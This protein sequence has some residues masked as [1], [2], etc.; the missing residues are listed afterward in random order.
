M[1]IVQD[2][3]SPKFQHL[4]EMSDSSLDSYKRFLSRERKARKAAECLL[5]AK[6]LEL[7][8]ANQKLRKQAQELDAR[9]KERTQQFEE[10]KAKAEAGAKAKSDFLANMSHEIR[11]PLNAIIGMNNLLLEENLTTR[12][13]EFVHAIHDSS[14]VLLRIINDILDFSKVA[15]GKLDIEVVEFSLLEV[16]DSVFELLRIKALN[17]GILFHF[18]IDP[19]IPERLNGDSGRL[20]Q[21][22]LNLLDNGIKFTS[23]GQV[24]LRLKCL[25]SDLDSCMV[26]LDVVD[27]GIGMSPEQLDVVFNPFTQA[28]EA[29]SRNYG[30]TGLGLVIAQKIVE[31][32]GGNL[33]VTSKERLG[34]TFTLSLPF[35]I[36]S[37][38]NDNNSKNNLADALG[39]DSDFL[40][41]DKEGMLYESIVS[42]LSYRGVASSINSSIQQSLR[43]VVSESG[44]GKFFWIL[45]FDQLSSVE[46]EMIR[47]FIRNKPE[48]VSLLLLVK[49]QNLIREFSDDDVGVLILPL[50]AKSFF[51]AIDDQVGNKTDV[52]SR[53]IDTQKLNKEQQFHDLR[54]LLAEDNPINQTVCRELLLLLGV[55]VDIAANGLEVL[56]MIDLFEYDLILMDIRMPE[57]SGL[58]ATRRIRKQ[59]NDIPIVAL[60]ANVLTEDQERCRAA[61]MN[62]FL[63]KPLIKKDLIEVIIRL[64]PD[65]LEKIDNGEQSQNHQQAK[66]EDILDYQTLIESLGGNKDF[67]DQI[68]VEFSDQA[69]RLIKEGRKAIQDEDFLNA[70]SIYHRLAGSSCSI[71]ANLLSRI[72][73]SLENGLAD[74][75]SKEEILHLVRELD[76]SFAQLRDMISNTK[77]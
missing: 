45:V 36:K 64:F 22:L 28:S 31:L 5:E 51:R 21:V 16:V 53:I 60:T 38:Q 27:T 17:K 71:R 50:S 67:A 77:A 20:Q 6:S 30:G 72:S 39:V 33:S 19:E 18:I 43:K 29:I 62:E 9:V 59:K 63:G 42:L 8:Y 12:Q 65:S 49:S 54:I 56:Q 68:L 52:S 7:Y 34:T 3:S 55:H 25:H 4:N 61:G 24:C 57:M 73:S 48:P 14:G 15:E 44:R 1:P 47:D 41:T 76:I 69:E 70:K 74:G 23:Q 75:T 40:I 26:Q 2:L 37:V 35:D 13:E 46:V 11:T 10:A 66:K 58:E 32:M